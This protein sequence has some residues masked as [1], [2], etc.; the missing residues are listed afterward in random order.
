MITNEDT[1]C[2]DFVTNGIGVN[3]NWFKFDNLTTDVIKNILTAN[4]DRKDIDF[5]VWHPDQV[6]QT[7]FYMHNGATILFDVN[8]ENYNSYIQP[9]ADIWQ[10]EKDRIE[11]EQQAAQDEYNKFENC[12]ARALTQLNEMFDRAANSAYVKSSL[13]FTADANSTAN[14]NVNGLLITIDDGTVQF[15]D[16]NNEFHE[17]NKSD[18]ETLRSEIIENGQSLYAQKWQYRTALEQATTN[19][20]LSQIIDSVTFTYSDFSK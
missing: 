12:Q 10:A 19:D 1:V 14:E 16:Y 20:Q 18:L 4:V 9:Y 17:L 8:E 15:C 2:V 3:D 7:G 5:I 6:S 13:G 11:Q